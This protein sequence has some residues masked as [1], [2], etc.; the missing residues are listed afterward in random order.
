MPT[1]TSPHSPGLSKAAPTE[2]VGGYR[3]ECGGI[4]HDEDRRLETWTILRGFAE[5][6]D[7]ELELDIYADVWNIVEVKRII[8]LGS[9]LPSQ[10]GNIPQEVIDDL[11]ARRNATKEK[12]YVLV[13]MC[14]Y[15][16]CSDK[17]RQRRVPVQAHSG[18]GAVENLRRLVNEERARDGR[19]SGLQGEGVCVLGNS[20]HKYVAHVY[21]N[22]LDST[23]QQ[24]YGT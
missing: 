13:G 6:G 20:T 9:R 11:L 16:D 19:E 17:P 5:I 8:A 24:L 22:V 12:F 4:E 23:K 7:V 21:A 15:V 14:R 3:T 2:L 18:R 1:K 10:G